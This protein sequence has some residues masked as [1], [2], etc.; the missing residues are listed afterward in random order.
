MSNYTEKLLN[1]DNDRHV[2]S[3]ISYMQHRLDEDAV[4]TAKVTKIIALLTV[5]TVLHAIIQIGFITL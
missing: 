4:R 2:S 3:V 1:S 5:L